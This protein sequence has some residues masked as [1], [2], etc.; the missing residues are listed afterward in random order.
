MELDHPDRLLARR[1]RCSLCQSLAVTRET[2]DTNSK[3]SICLENVF[4]TSLS[5]D[6]PGNRGRGA[7]SPRDPRNWPRLKKNAQILV[8]AFHSMMGT[9]IAVG[10]IPA[11]D[12]FAEQ[13]NVTVPAASYLTSIQV[14]PDLASIGNG[15]GV[16]TELHEP[17]KRAQKFGWWTLTTIGTPGGPSF[18]GFV[19]K[20]IGVQWI[21]WIFA[22]INFCQFLFYLAIGDETTHNPENEL[23]STGDFSKIVPR[24]INSH[25]LRVRDIVALFSLAKYPR[26]MIV[27]C[28]HTITFAMQTLP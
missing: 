4:P 24:Q 28:A 22:I 18:M 25:P 12:V 13:Y 5:Y 23:K 26:V 21:F 19:I 9:F 7:D 16:V 14:L 10:I 11:F 8:A 3:T 17:E 20:H 27:A 1:Q 15:S 2:K 6:W